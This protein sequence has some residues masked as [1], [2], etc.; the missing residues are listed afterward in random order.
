[1]HQLRRVSIG[2]VQVELLWSAR[3]YKSESKVV[4]HKIKLSLQLIKTFDDVKAAVERILADPNIIVSSR[5]LLY[6]RGK[7]I[8]YG[9][10]STVY[11]CLNKKSVVLKFVSEN[12]IFKR[13]V[14]LYEQLGEFGSKLFPT[15]YGC[16]PNGYIIIE[17]FERDLNGVNR[18]GPV[19]V[20][21][22]NSVAISCL[23]SISCLHRLG[24]VHC[25]VKPAN[26]LVSEL[27]SGCS[28]TVL[29]D[30][31]LAR[32]YRNY[33]YGLQKLDHRIGTELYMSRDIHNHAQP[34]RRSDLESLGWTLIEVY[35]GKLPWKG[36]TNGTIGIQ[37]QNLN[38]A[39]FLSKCFI[40]AYPTQLYNYLSLVEKL[41]YNE[42][43]DY[44]LLKLC[45]VQDIC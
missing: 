34:T 17:R 14:A 6:V 44:T 1:M 18:S 22:C 7:Q 36:C 3:M 10:F 42:T 4:G 26:I 38:V 29:A 25:D 28:N 33:P 15:Y 2:L 41:E 30:F 12:R 27:S 40:N 32:V 21:D 9:G 19:P 5:G 20:E 39:E 45:F 37:K 35:G 16:T 24:Y 8:A 31:G 13:E 43:P 23:N 11:S